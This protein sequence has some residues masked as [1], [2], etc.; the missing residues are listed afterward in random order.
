MPVK[1]L[2]TS[3]A[4]LL[5]LVLVARGRNRSLNFGLFMD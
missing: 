5:S 1:M 4:K 2:A 3:D